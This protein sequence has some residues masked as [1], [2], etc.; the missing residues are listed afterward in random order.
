MEL[1]SAFASAKPVHLLGELLGVIALCRNTMNSSFSDSIDS[2]G[3]FHE[4]GQADS[5]AVT[6]PSVEGD[7]GA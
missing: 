7:A 3:A 1:A 4:Q 6:C 5:P 2:T